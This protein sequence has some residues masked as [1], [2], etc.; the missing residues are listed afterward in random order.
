M[1][2]RAPLVVFAGTSFSVGVTDMILERALR[3]SARIFSVDPAARPAHRRIEI[4]AQPAEVVFPELVSKLL[5]SA[6]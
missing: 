2:K 4:I 3:R 5:A 1:A 6:D